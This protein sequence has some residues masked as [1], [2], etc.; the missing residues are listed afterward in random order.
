MAALGSIRKRGVTLIIIV[1]LGLFAFIAGDMFKGC[2][3][4]EARSVSRWVKC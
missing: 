4:F 2:E 1:A 3:Y